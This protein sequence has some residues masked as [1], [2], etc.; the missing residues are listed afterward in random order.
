MGGLGRGR[1]V[2]GVDAGALGLARP[3]PFGR[4]QGWGSGSIRAAAQKV[5]PEFPASSFEKGE[6]VLNHRLLPAAAERGGG[7]ALHPPLRYP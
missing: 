5:T 3:G 6:A 4:M 1:R 7:C 2:A